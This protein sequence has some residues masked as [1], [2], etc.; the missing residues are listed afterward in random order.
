MKLIL[1]TAILGILTVNGRP[2]SAIH[3]A[4]ATNFIAHPA[5]TKKVT[6]T[7]PA[8]AQ[9]VWQNGDYKVK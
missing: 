9:I 4:V 3:E 8:S 6:T 7:T 2:V 5:I 1:S